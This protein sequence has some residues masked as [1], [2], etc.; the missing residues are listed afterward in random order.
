MN[1]LCTWWWPWIPK[2]PASLPSTIVTCKCHHTVCHHLQRIKQ[3]FFSFWSAGDW[4]Q[5][6]ALL[7]KHSTA[8]L[9]P[10]REL[11]FYSFSWEVLSWSLNHFLRSSAFRQEH[12]LGCPAHSR[13][14]LGASHPYLYP[15]HLYPCPLSSQWRLVM[16]VDD[17]KR[18]RSW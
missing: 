7:V 1:S 11:V 4:T 18:D 9:Y 12:V 10:F 8:K 17:S 5:G 2:P 6:L 3:F 13:T 14:W 16:A 15:L